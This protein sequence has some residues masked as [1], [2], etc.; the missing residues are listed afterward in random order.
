M[1]S[2]ETRTERT[3]GAGDDSDDRSP[4]VGVMTSAQDA[5]Q[6]TAAAVRSAAETAAEHL[7]S[8]VASAQE[9]S[10]DTAR[11]LDDLPDQALVIGTSFSMGLGVG[12]FLSGSNRLLVALALVPAAAMAATLLN[13]DQPT[14][15][16]RRSG[17]QLLPAE[18]FPS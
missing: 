14:A 2:P 18:P 15:D 11:V 4:L 6:T 8:A 5:A 12:L 13:R 3:N 17:R 16:A 10:R 9:V 7:P 1:P